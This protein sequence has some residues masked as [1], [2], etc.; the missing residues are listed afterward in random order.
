MHIITHNYHSFAVYGGNRE[1][2]ISNA[3]KQLISIRL[4]C[5][6]NIQSF[7]D[8]RIFRDDLDAINIAIHILKE[9]LKEDEKK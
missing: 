2:T 5:E 4:Q 1:M 7:P 3:L 8:E 6:L 9:M